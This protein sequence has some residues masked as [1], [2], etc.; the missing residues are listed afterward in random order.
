M[1]NRQLT[2]AQAL[3]NLRD[4]VGFYISTP[5]RA[6]EALAFAKQL[7]EFAA[8]LEDKVKDRAA[9]IMH[10]EGFRQIEYGEYVAVWVD[11]SI[12]RKYDAQAVF[13]ALGPN[14]IEVMEVSTAK[15]MKHLSKNH[16]E[17]GA[18]SEMVQNMTETPR[19]G[20]VMTKRKAAK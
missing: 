17:G 9:S 13:K 2:N 7:K 6:G 19:L 4:Q 14:S 11:A 18:L 8:E 20:Y 12:V 5:E 16:I 3:Q 10:R 1:T 15:L